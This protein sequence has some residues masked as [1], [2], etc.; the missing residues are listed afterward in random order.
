MDVVQ[1]L[2][3]NGILPGVLLDVAVIPFMVPFDDKN[4]SELL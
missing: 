1:S 3:G 2:L 4:I